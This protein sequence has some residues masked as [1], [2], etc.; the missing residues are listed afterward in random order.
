[1]RLSGV[2]KR[3][4]KPEQPI[5]VEVVYALPQE[6]KVVALTLERGATVGDALIRSA[7]AGEHSEI[8]LAQ[9]R[10]GIYGRRVSSETI[11]ADGDRVEIYRPLTADPKQAR[12]RRA[13]RTS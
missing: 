13:S 1:M 11:L 5:R 6:Q 8:D 4:S 9:C 3:S 7:L 2:L 10:V 12:R